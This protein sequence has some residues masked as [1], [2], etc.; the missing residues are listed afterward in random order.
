MDICS[1]LTF[2]VFS[3]STPS[4]SLSLQL[5]PAYCLSTLFLHRPKEQTISCFSIVTTHIF[6]FPLFHFRPLNI[7]GCCICPLALLSLCFFFCFFLPLF[8]SLSFFLCFFF[9]SLRHPHSQ[10]Q[11]PT[12]CATHETIT[13]RHQP[14]HSP[15]HPCS[16]HN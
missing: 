1:Q 10:Q 11:Q 12:L 8:S 14:L 4:L 9:H 2:S 13:R 3:R 5:Q 7:C 6:T 15:Y 16:Y